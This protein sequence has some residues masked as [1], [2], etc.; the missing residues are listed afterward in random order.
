MAE[1][2]PIPWYDRLLTIDRRWIYLIMGIA[3]VI[4]VI[5]EMHI[6]VTESSEVRAVY[7]FT[8]EVRDGEI[9]LLAIDYDPST[10]AELHPMSEVILRQVWNHGGRLLFS[11][12][13]QFGPAMAD[14]MITRIAE[15]VGAEYGVDY[16]FL[17]YK[18]Y[19]A[20]VILAMGTDFRVPFPTDYYGQDIEDLPMMDGVHNY[21]DVEGV[22]ALAGGNGIN[23]TVISVTI[24]RVPSEP[25]MSLVRS[26]PVTLFRVFPPVLI[27]S[28]EGSTTWSPNR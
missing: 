24:P 18:P 11:S 16:V 28:P 25:H 15:E 12:L 17:G 6:P 27:T 26:Y 8:D 13:S 19:P 5:W 21:D 14:E 7:E 3:V 23:L 9:L 10:M 20:I 22:V 4:P 1:R 2:K